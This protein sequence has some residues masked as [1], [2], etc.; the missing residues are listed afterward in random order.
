MLATAR[1]QGL[2]LEA[3]VPTNKFR[4]Q[5]HSAIPKKSHEQAKKLVEQTN[6]AKKNCVLLCGEN[7]IDNEIVDT[8]VYLC[9]SF[10]FLL[11]FDF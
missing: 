8:C 6:L 5:L 11:M 10:V 1:L 4:K 9:K 7:K 2:K 3:Q